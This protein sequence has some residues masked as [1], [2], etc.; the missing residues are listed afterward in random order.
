MGQPVAL[1]MS[2]LP[3][4][5]CLTWSQIIEVAELLGIP[6]NDLITAFALAQD[7]DLFGQLQ[8][9]MR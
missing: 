4:R 5:P 6:I 1:L 2:P 7:E 3:S 9:G 8:G